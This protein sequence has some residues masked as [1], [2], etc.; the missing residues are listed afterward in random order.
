MVF[1][2]IVFLTQL[3]KVLFLVGAIMLTIIAIAILAVV[4]C[5]IIGTIKGQIKKEEK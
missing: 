4:V 5:S 1:D 3:L 2:L